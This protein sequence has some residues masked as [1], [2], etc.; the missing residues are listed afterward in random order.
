MLRTRV[1]VLR[2]GPSSEFDISLATGKT[3]LDNLPEERYQALDIFIDKKGEWHR[4][5]IPVTPAKVIHDIDVI[6]NALHGE[7][8]EDGQVQQLLEHFSMPYTGSSALA[9]AISLNKVLTK[10][11]LIQSHIKTPC[12]RVVEITPYLHEELAEI[13]RTFPQ[14][15]VVKP[16]NGGSSIGVSIADNY[17][18]LCKGV[19]NAFNYSTK[20]IIEEFISGR[21]GTLAVIDDFRNQRVYPLLPVE[22]R[23]HQHK[24]FFDFEAK[25]NGHSDEIC[26]GDFSKAELMEIEK[27]VLDAHAVLG[28]RHYSRTD[29]IINP[30][31]GVYILEVNTL[32]GLTKGSLLP[33]SLDA[34]G[35]KLSEFLTHVISLAQRKNKY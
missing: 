10:K 2:G 29:F 8:G 14:P 26:P 28:L 27:S 33:K 17:E 25:Y 7:Y 15:S 31:R 20:V 32:P 23:P 16:Y 34:V 3:V 24:E 19:A 9:S 5:G 21:E 22:I 35:I 12:Y 18:K 30:R 13:F 6:F 4:G 1:G 11:R